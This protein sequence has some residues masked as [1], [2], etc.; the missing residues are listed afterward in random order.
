MN[1]R[2]LGFA[3]I[4]TFGLTACGGGSM[5]TPPPPPPP[6]PILNANVAVN[7]ATGGGF[8]LAMSTSFQ[9]AEWDY[10]FFQTSLNAKTALLGNLLPQHI[11]L[12]GISKGVPQGASGTSSTNWDF[13]T[14]DAITQPVLTV[15]DNSPQFQI[16]KAPPF[17]Y[18]GNDSSKSFTDLTFQ[19]FAGY[20]QDLVLYYNKGGFNAPDGFHASPSGLPIT[21]WGIYNEPSINNNLTA[22]QY[23]TMYN[24]V[25][26]AMQ[27]ADSTL[28]FVA[29]EMCCGSENWVPTFAAGVTAQVDVVASH[30]YSS[31]NQKDSDAQLMATVPNFVSSVQSITASLST[32]PNLANVP[33]WVTENNVNADFNAGNGTSACNPGQTFVTDKRGSSP[34]F[35]AWRPYV[36]SQLGK[37][38][39]QALYHWDFDADAQ[40][41]EVDFNS[42]NPQLSY[43]VDYWLARM[44]PAGSQQQQLQFSNSANPQIEVLPVK[45]PNGS[46]V[47]MLSNHAVASPGDNNGPGLIAKISLDVSALGTFN[48]A[49][50]LMIDST[51]SIANG[52]SAVNISPQSP[53]NLTLDG[54]SVAFITL[55]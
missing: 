46:V 37:A 49:S 8:D 24:A 15:G 10:A 7:N 3:L 2:A 53:I 36:F 38:G 18:S 16:A 11:R 17:M 9:P 25:V 28:K 19:Q 51:T 20:A 42:G 33:I 43:W 26:P 47:I 23:T 31:C 12:Q 5:S 54:Y 13:S 39:V 22:A 40:Y 44:F 41:G 14:L 34:F 6:P 1:K 27:A 29:L 35:A 50:L 45:N 30:Y 32:N 21:W 4:L 55:Q 48:S 52:P